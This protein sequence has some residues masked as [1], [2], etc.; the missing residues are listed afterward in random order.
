MT[1]PQPLC[2]RWILIPGCTPVDLRRSCSTRNK[3]AKAVV[4]AKYCTIAGWAWNSCGA[5][6]MYRSFA[7][8]MFSCT[9]SSVEWMTRRHFQSWRKLKTFSQ[10]GYFISLFFFF[11]WFI[12]CKYQYNFNITCVYY[13]GIGFINT[14]CSCLFV[15]LHVLNPILASNF[16]DTFDQLFLWIFLYGFHRKCPLYFFYTMVQNKSKMTKN[17]NQGVGSC[18]QEEVKKGTKKLK[19]TKDIICNMLRRKTLE[20]QALLL[21]FLL[22]PKRHLTI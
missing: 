11:L 16:S 6:C 1:A 13:V 20:R 22:K 7:C 15:G 8:L 19:E 2:V 10:K 5:R 9:A 12:E 21:N 14:R 3:F 4:Q 18:L 17:S